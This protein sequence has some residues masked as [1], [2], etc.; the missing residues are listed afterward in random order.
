MGIKLYTNTLNT[1]AIGISGIIPNEKDK[2]RLFIAADLLF[3]K[4]YS[5]S[6]SHIIEVEKALPNEFVNLC[7]ST[8]FIAITSNKAFVC[9]HDSIYPQSGFMTALGTGSK[10]IIGCYYVLR[11]VALAFRISSELDT[12]SSAEYMCVKADTLN[13][14][15]ME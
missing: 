1:I 9:H 7:Q 8:E 5:G 15:I 6:L 4:M 11:D 3:K 13:P 14:Y 12:W 2:I 10:S